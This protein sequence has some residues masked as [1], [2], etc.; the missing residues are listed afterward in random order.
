M[1]SSAIAFDKL[2]T[3][4]ILASKS[5]PTPKYLTLYHLQKH[6]VWGQLTKDIA[7]KKISY[8]FFLKKSQSGSSIGVF[9]IENEEHLKTSIEEMGMSSMCLI[10]FHRR[11][12]RRAGGY[13]RHLPK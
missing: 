1:L 3:K 13:R 12:N 5:I 2:K 7:A 4:E 10:L 8:P 11:K 6:F 9:L